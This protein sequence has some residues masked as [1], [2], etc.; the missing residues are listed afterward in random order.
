MRPTPEALYGTWKLI[1]N[2]LE[3]MDGKIR[4]P[5]GERPKGYLTLTP[6]NRF[7]AILAADQRKTGQSIDELAALQRS[8]IGYTGRFTLEPNPADLDGLILKNRVEVAW[9]EAWAGTEQIR[10]LSLAG[11]ILTITAS[12]QV[13]AFGDKIRRA[14]IVWERSQ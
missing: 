3:D 6:D 11:K 14:T 10:Y 13:S 4:Y 8:F 5:L 2:T 9:N 1:S 7:V 12:P